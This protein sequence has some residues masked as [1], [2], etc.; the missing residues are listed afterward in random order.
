MVSVCKATMRSVNYNKLKPV[1]A[2]LSNCPLRSCSVEIL[3]AV[4]GRGMC[5]LTASAGPRKQHV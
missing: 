3:V 1:T 2:I 5:I 4:F